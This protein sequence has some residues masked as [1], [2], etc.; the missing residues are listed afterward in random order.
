MWALAWW[1]ML[2]VLPVPWL[3]RRTARQ[4]Q[5]DRGAALEVPAA[6]PL[7]SLAA[8]G[9]SGQRR[10]WAHALLWAVWVLAVFASARPQFVGEQLS[11]PISGRD[12][13][14]AVDLS[15]S[16]E[17]QD[18]VLNGAPVD[19]LTATIV[20]ASEFIEQRVGDRL[21]LILFGREA[22]IGFIFTMK[23]LPARWEDLPGGSR[24]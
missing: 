12:L 8:T 20:V 1:W 15:G 19:R 4:Q 10:R 2:L 22:L 3:L 17:E 9:A 18:F 16:M 23:I 21:G 14:L 5:L 7:A 24:T 6:S 13:L 11:L